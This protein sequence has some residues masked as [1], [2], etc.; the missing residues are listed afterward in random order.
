MKKIKKILIII[1]IIYLLANIFLFFNQKNM[2]YFPNKTDF[3]NC[4]NFTKK[5]KKFYT[6]YKKEPFLYHDVRFY[7]VSWKNNNVIIF[8][9]WNAWRACERIWILKM[10]KKTGIQLFFQNIFDMLIGKEIHQ[11]LK[12]FWKM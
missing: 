3:L 4:D 12:V 10:L 11:I 2:L 6:N 7:E 8:F 5:Q 1:L 9:H